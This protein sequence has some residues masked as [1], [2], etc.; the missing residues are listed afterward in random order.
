MITIVNYQT[1]YIYA[2]QQ[3]IS[4]PIRTRNKCLREFIYR[5]ECKIISQASAR[6]IPLLL[7]KNNQFAVVISEA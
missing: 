1:K 3:I 6:F 7:K 2:N 5:K 4:N